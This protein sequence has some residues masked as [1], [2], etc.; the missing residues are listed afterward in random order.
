MVYANLDKWRNW[1]ELER[2]R[3]GGGEGEESR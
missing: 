1:I 3:G 2:F